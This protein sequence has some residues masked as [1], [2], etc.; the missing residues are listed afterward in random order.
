MDVVVNFDGISGTITAAKMNTGTHGAA[1]GTWTTP[2]GAP[3]HT[4]VVDHDVALPFAFRVAGTNY[5]GTTALGVT[6]DFSTQPVGADVLHYGLSATVSSCQLMYLA[7]YQTVL[8]GGSPVS[9]NCDLWVI[10]GTKFSV[11]QRQHTFANVK[12]F[13][14]H[15][16]G[17]LGASI[18]DD[19]GWVLV[20]LFHNAAGGVACLLVQQVIQSG[21]NWILGDILGT[22]TGALVGA[23]DVVYFRFQ[24]YLRPAS[25]TGTIKVKIAGLRNSVL[26]W[27]PY[28]PGTIPAPG[29][30]TVT[31]SAPDE[32]TLTWTNVCDT[33]R[34]ERKTGSGSYST[35]VSEYENNGDDTY[36]DSTVTDGNTYT[37]RV[38][39][40]VG[41]YES[42]SGESNAVTI[43][44]T[45]TPAAGCVLWL[46]ADSLVLS[47]GDPV[48]T[49]SD[50]SGLGN[51]VTQAVAGA[52]P[53]YKTN[54][55]NGLPV[56][57]GD[58]G[59]HLAHTGVV[60]AN[61]QHTWMIVLKKS[62]TNTTLPFYNGNTAS[63]GW[64]A[65]QNASG[66]RAELFGGAI[67]KNDGTPSATDFEIWEA[68]WDGSV[69]TLLVNG[70]DEPLTDPSI[71]PVAPSGDTLVMGLAG[72]NQWNGDVAEILVWDNA[73][74]APNRLLARQ[75]LGTKYGITVV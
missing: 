48:T 34:I 6:F 55:L 74:S 5:D 71:P 40:I 14:A 45:F 39:T 29:S 57:R 38:T 41:A 61:E 36:V 23:G 46:K 33:F 8:D 50:S 47:D 19:E 31:Q 60:T 25:G 24:D 4:T 68:M 65:F 73:V 64:G 59:D 9:Y 51:N 28:N 70:V 3:N 16:D 58:G 66:E 10:A 52:K 30:V 49:W 32:A 2:E 53:T 11:P 22:S 42:S 69:S 20:S 56:V 15:T 67:S 43:D 7:R 27:P 37:Y 21:P 75:Y 17:D 12:I 26:T 44:N 18:T 13:C 72:S 35:L 63:N 54:I 62:G 1:W